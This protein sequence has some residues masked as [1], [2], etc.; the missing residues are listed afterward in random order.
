MR[1]NSQR[2]SLEDWGQAPTRLEPVVGIV[3]LKHLEDVR[4]ISAQ[5]LDGAGRPFGESIVLD[6][7][8]EGWVLPLGSSTTPWFAISV[9][10]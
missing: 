5:P 9:D 8:P 4:A 7:S 10:R 6:S 1:W 3:R 2:N